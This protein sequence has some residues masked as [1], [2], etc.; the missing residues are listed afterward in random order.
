MIG[1]EF[2]SVINF[3]IKEVCSKRE[4]PDDIQIIQTDNLGEVVEKLIIVHIRMWM[5]EDS[6][7]VANDAQEIAELKK[8]TDICFKIKRPRLVEAINLIINEAIINNK[9][10]LEDSVK[11]YEGVDK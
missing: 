8:K 2:D 6:L 5:I 10:L 3:C 9:S 7:G 4:V 1:K 11:L